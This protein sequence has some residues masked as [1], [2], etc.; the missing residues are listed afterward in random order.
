[1]ERIRLLFEQ[2]DEVKRLM[3]SVTS[4]LNFRIA[5]ILIDNTAELIMNRDLRYPPL[6]TYFF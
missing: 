1:M 3:S 5:M 4:V 2:I 6:V